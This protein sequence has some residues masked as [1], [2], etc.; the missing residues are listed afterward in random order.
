MKHQREYFSVVFLEE[1]QDIME[2]KLW[3]S[4][5]NISPAKSQARLVSKEETTERLW[6][7][8]PKRAGM[9]RLYL[10]IFALIDI[11][12]SEKPRKIKTFKKEIEVR[13]EEKPL[14]WQ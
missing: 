8:S 10:D 1:S 4:A 6:E 12:G 11:N 2:A 3:G 9:H 13:A 5:F 7:I 14:G